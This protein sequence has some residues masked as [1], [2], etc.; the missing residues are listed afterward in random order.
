MAFSRAT[1][2][3]LLLSLPMTSC[4]K[5]VDIAPEN[6]SELSES[7]ETHRVTTTDGYV[8]VTTRVTARDSS[9]VLNGLKKPNAVNDDVAGIPREPVV[10]PLTNVG[11]VERVDTHTG[12][13]ALIMIGVFAALAAAVGSFHGYG[14]ST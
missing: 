6:Y 9:L 7:R 11:F 1:I 8:Y 5:Y 13:T 2:T 12:R 14:G 10:V 3:I 4:A